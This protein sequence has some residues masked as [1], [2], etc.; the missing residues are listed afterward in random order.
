MYMLSTSRSEGGASAAFVGDRYMDNQSN[1][2][3]MHI[4]EAIR[5][6]GIGNIRCIPDGGFPP[7]YEL[8]S[9]DSTATEEVR[10][11]KVV[12]VKDILKNRKGKIAFFAKR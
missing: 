4:Y 7:F 2:Q 5:R 9:D 3:S 11:A 10:I 1:G 12:E 8:R 6:G